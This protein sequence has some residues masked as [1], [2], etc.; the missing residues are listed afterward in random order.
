LPLTVVGDGPLED[1]LRATAGPNIRFVGWLSGAGVRAH[2]AQAR[3][4]VFAADEEFGIAP[5]EAQAAGVPVIAHAGGGVLETVIPEETGLLFP[6]PN[7]ESL[8]QAVRDFESGRC[9]F[10]PERLRSN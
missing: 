9:R 3:A 4:L 2:L 6:D 8:I 1:R 7:P 5:V 10:D